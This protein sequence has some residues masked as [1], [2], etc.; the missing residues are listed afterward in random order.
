MPILFSIVRDISGVGVP[1]AK[2]AF[3]TASPLPQFSGGDVRGANDLVVT[4]S[5][6]GYW[7]SPIEPGEYF[8]WI[9]MGRRRRIVVPTTPDYIML[10]D[11]FS[12]QI[13]SAGTAGENWRLSSAER[14]LVNADSGEFQTVF[15]DDVAGLKELGFVAPGFGSATENFRY[16]SGMLELFCSETNTWHAPYLD[17]GE[18]ALAAHNSTPQTVDRMLAARWQIRDITTGLFRSWFIT[19]ADG[20]EALAFGPEEA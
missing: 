3:R 12:G 2:L 15:I 18:F 9:G 4:S 20:A 8:V 5:N 11:L 1:G 13:G 19:G 6:E 7:S 16:R 17:D 14:Q 10:G